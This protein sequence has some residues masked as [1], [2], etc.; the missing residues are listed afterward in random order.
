M[1]T[2]YSNFKLYVIN[3]QNMTFAEI[4]NSDGLYK[5]VSFS[6][7][8]CFQIKNGTL[9]SVTYK[10]VNDLLPDREPT[11]V[12]KDLFNNKY[13]KIYTIKQLFT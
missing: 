12:N 6:N 4:F 11:V 13:Q 7:G 8:V 9:Y 2:N 5:S 1:Y 10:N 3:H